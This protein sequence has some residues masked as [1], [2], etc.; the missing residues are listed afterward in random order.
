MMVET[1]LVKELQSEGFHWPEM[2]RIELEEI[3][4]VGD[5]CGSYHGVGSAYRCSRFL[6]G[7][8]KLGGET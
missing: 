7:E 1:K 3:R 6:R 5:S 8:F 4:L 2:L